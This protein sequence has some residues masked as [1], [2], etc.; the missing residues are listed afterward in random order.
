MKQVNAKRS[1]YMFMYHHHLTAEQYNN[2][3]VANKSFENIAKLKYLGIM[4]TNQNCI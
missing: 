1:K 4:V 2:I 3:K